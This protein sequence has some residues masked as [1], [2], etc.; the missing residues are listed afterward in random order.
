MPS[1]GLPSRSNAE[2]NVKL[3]T[4]YGE[5]LP[6]DVGVLMNKQPFGFPSYGTEVT[7]DDR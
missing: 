1:R 4:V 2:L 3:I 6:P 7:R 5:V